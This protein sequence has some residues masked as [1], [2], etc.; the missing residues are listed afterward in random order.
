MSLILHDLFLTVAI[1]K[2]R[3][4][5]R[6]CDLDAIL[7]SIV[8]IRAK[9]TGVFEGRGVADR[10]LGVGRQLGEAFL[11]KDIVFIQ[12]HQLA[13][14]GRACGNRKIKESGAFFS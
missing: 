11:P 4:V 7:D 5:I 3:L 13:R 6:R 2:I 8:P 9:V 14:E 1:L 10:A 12:T